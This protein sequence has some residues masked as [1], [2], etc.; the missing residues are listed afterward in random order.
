MLFG[1]MEA[2]RV[3]HIEVAFDGVYEK[4]QVVP[5][6]GIPQDLLTESERDVLERIYKKFSD[7]GS[8]EISNYSHKEK[9]YRLTKRGEIISYEFAKEI[10]LNN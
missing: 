4:H 6:K 7:F 10:Q 2:D 8:V 3:V 9:G 5:E 1:M